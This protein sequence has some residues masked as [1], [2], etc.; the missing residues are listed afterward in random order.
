M[1]K[2]ENVADGTS[3]QKGG[4]AFEPGATQSNGKGVKKK[5][6]RGGK[7]ESPVGSWKTHNVCKGKLHVR[8]DAANR[9]GI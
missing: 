9:Q 1:R 2:K 7:E 5:N 8:R 3:A 4:P 6:T